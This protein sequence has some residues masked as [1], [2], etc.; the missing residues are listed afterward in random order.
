MAN[1]HMKKKNNEHHLS[2]GKCKS[3]QDTTSYSH[4]FFKEKK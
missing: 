1:K 2:L 4:F 3:K